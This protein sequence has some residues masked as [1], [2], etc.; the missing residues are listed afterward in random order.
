MKENFG[1]GKFRRK[2]NKFAQISN[3]ALQ[4]NGLSLKAKGL[5]SLIQSMI[6]MPDADLRI[7][8]IRV[9]CK[10]GEKSFSSAWKELKDA[11][12]L[13][14]YRIPDGK[15]GAFRYEYD[16]LEEPDLTTSAT[17]NLNKYGEI[18][19]ID[20]AGDHIPQNGGD[21]ES[22]ATDQLPDHV[23]Q[24]GGYGENS[25][26]ASDHS[27][28]NGGGGQPEE[29]DPDHTPH[30][31]P[32]AKSTLCFSD[33]VQKGGDNSN[34]LFNNTRIDNIKSISQSSSDGRTDEIRDRLKNQIDYSYFEVNRPEDLQIINTLID[35]MAEMLANPTTKINGVE[36]SRQCLA[37][38]IN[39][40]DST[41]ITEFMEDMRGKVSGVKNIS[42]YLRSCLINFIRDQNLI[43]MTV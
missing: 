15:K 30:F 23:P 6:T 31:G 26:I 22:A 17:I 9:K 14:Q 40:V 4:D 29:K 25:K 39:Q 27:P 16:L 34:T 8:K 41:T 33:P 24:N 7:W 10:E 1:S 38:Y 11:G 35:C 18:S 37:E 20:A 13:K 36:Q 32:Y 21:G 5:Y 19:S 2:K 43:L 12:Y 28:Q 3:I 42:A